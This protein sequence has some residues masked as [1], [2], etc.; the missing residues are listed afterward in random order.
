LQA[1]RGLMPQAPRRD[2]RG[3]RPPRRH[4][5]P[6]ETRLKGVKTLFDQAAAR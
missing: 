2:T 1:L 5:C 6:R 3:E 4:R